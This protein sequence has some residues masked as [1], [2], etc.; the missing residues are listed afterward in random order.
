[1]IM[2]ENQ[3]RKYRSAIERREFESEK[4]MNEE[5]PRKPRSAIEDKN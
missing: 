4:V 5:Q 2:S 3:P 1:M